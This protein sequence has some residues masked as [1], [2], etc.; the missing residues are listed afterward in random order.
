[1]GREIVR[2]EKDSGIY[3]AR[4]VH[5]ILCIGGAYK[6]YERLIQGEERIIQG[7]SIRGLRYV[8]ECLININRYEY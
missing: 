3:N 4:Q 8:C 2:Q 1:M 7:L 5:I 6:Y